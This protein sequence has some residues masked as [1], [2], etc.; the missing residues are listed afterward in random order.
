MSAKT[1]IERYVRRGSCPDVPKEELRR[2]L[3]GVAS[4]DQ[5]KITDRELDE[6]V[7]SI[8]GEKPKRGRNSRR[9]SKTGEHTTPDDLKAFESV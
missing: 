3:A 9:R 8:T 2:H 5:L 7:F 4:R 6:V 1:I